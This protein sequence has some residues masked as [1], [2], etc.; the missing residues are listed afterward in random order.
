MADSLFFQGCFLRAC[1]APTLSGTSSARTHSLPASNSIPIPWAPIPTIYS[2]LPV[3]S[4][5]SSSLGKLP[6]CLQIL[7]RFDL[8]EASLAQWLFCPLLHSVSPFQRQHSIYFSHVSAPA[9][10]EDKAKII[11]ISSVWISGQAMT[12]FVPDW[13]RNNVQKQ[14]NE[15]APARG[16][17]E[18]K[19]TKMH[20]P[21]LATHLRHL[22][23][24]SSLMLL[25]ASESHG[26][27]LFY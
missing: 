1:I 9:N 10:S 6:S 4:K 12:V 25:A 27:C 3:I 20:F 5:P 21:G 14:T 13:K 26:P 7:I 23:G 22:S 24:I 8:L 18:W 15:Y 11:Y 16:T 19:V 17:D 2:C